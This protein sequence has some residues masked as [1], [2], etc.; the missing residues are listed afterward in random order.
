[1]NKLKL[2]LPVLIFLIFELSV[3]I[4]LFI[5]P[6]GFT[7]AVI[8]SFG[9]M[10][11]VNAVIFL[12]RYLVG[13]RRDDDSGAVNIAVSVA[14]LIIG[15]YCVIFTDLIMG[16]FAVL[17]MIYGVFLIV[18]GIFKIKAYADSR[19]AGL[20]GSFLMIATAVLSII[21]GTVVVLHPFAATDVMWRFTGAS[22]VFEAVFDLVA[23]IVTMTTKSAD[24]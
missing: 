12:V 10:N 22:L 13:R 4:L 2:N 24:E 7:R 3:G 8:I 21:L 15:L 5:E 19:R 16:L 17:A 20:R 14:S 23:L 9:V 6:E 11:I 1:M 18:S